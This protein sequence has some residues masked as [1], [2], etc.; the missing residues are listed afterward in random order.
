QLVAYLTGHPDLNHLRRHLAD[1]LPTYMVPTSL[2]TLPELPLTP[3]GKLDTARLPEPTPTATEHVA[4]HTDTEQWL[5]DTWQNLLDLDQVSA[6]DN[7]FD[8]GG[9][10]LLG[11]QLA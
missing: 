10:S 6:T 5:A 4:P 9:N 7:F 11:T 2:I 1:R 8:L 3:N